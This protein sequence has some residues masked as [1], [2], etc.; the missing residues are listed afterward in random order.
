MFH[1]RNGTS[2]GQLR[3]M[4]GW[5][6]TNHGGLYK[7]GKSGW[8]NITAKD[9]YRERNPKTSSETEALKPLRVLA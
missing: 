5:Q 1:R 7:L 8:R 9:Q 2:C 3:T 6:F 4:H